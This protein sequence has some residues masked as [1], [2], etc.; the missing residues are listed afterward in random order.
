VGSVPIAEI[1][2]VKVISLEQA[3]E[4]YKELR[5]RRCKQV[6]HR[7][8]RATLQGGVSAAPSAC[9]KFEAWLMSQAC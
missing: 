1:V 2:N 7:S 9:S 5:R 6:R 8:A 3:P 4:G